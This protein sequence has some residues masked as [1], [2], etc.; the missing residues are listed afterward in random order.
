MTLL[1]IA[2]FMLMSYKLKIY[3][4]HEYSTDA[5]SPKTCNSIKGLAAIFFVLL[6]VCLCMKFSIGNEITMFLGSISYE[7]YLVHRILLDV[8]LNRIT[9][10]Y[11]YLVVCL[12]GAILIGH[13]FNRF[14]KNVFSINIKKLNKNKHNEIKC[15]NI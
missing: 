14:M 4:T 7:I 11:M 13:L 10:P 9:N 1:Y 2:I 8:F 15:D 12:V 5:L 6:C 3:D